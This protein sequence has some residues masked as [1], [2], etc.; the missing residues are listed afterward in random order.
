MP[1]PDVRGH[2]FPLPL[3]CTNATLA[4]TFEICVHT[5][6]GEVLK[7][8][9]FSGCFCRQCFEIKCVDIPGQSDFFEGPWSGRCRTGD[10]RVSV[11]VQ[12]TDSCPECK[13][14]HIDIQAATFDKVRSSINI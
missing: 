12:I 6:Q 4:G 2:D 1:V 5:F 11:I 3:A 13:A 9:G 14:D 8:H 7:S 10:D